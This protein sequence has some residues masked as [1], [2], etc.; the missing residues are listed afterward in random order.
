MVSLLKLQDWNSC[1]S[2]RWSPDFHMSCNHWGTCRRPPF[3]GSHSLRN[4]AFKAAL[5]F[6]GRNMS[7]HPMWNSINVLRP[8]KAS[9]IK[10]VRVYSDWLLLRIHFFSLGENESNWYI[11]KATCSWLLNGWSSIRLGLFGWFDEIIK[12]GIIHRGII[13]WSGN[14]CW[15]HLSNGPLLATCSGSVTFPKEQRSHTVINLA[16]CKQLM[17]FGSYLAMVRIGGTLD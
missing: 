15:G 10:Y 8:N 14:Y 9:Q 7:E 1:A 3:F 2:F 6:V 17:H 13:N 5:S 12:F 16:T 4:R 11:S